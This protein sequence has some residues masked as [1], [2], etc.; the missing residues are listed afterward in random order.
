[1]SEGARL[2][3]VDDTR[4]RLATADDLA[5]ITVIYNAEVTGGV[6]TFDTTPVTVD[7]FASSVGST[8]PGD[9]FLVATAGESVVGYVTSG[10]FRARPAYA[11][12]RET[13]VY[14]P[15]DGR[16]LG[17][18]TSLYT[19]LLARLD[20]SGV[21]T[22]MAVIALP[23]DAS[24]ALHRR[25]GFS[26]V[27]TLREVGRKFDRWIDTAWYQRISPDGSR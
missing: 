12:T 27:G 2:Q 18:A 4:V 5:D 19:E 7:H 9:V 21:H 20:A 26:S 1:M 14:V 15:P 11:A 24:E 25:L 13:S 10:P 8:A 17:L 16:G 6:A 22:Q 3:S 23:N